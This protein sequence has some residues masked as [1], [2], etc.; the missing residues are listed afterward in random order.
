MAY[1]L[2]IFAGLLTTATELV[3]YQG[4]QLIFLVQI[5]IVLL[6]FLLCRR[7]SFDGPERFS[8]TFIALIALALSAFVTPA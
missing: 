6:C 2:A 7:E 3:S 1:V 4:A 5:V 8:P